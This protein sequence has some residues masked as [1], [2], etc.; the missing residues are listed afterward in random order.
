MNLNWISISQNT[1]RGYNRLIG[2]TGATQRIVIKAPT[3]EP[4]VYL[5]DSK[6]FHERDLYEFFDE[7][8]LFISIVPSAEGFSYRIYG[9]SG[10]LLSDK[11]PFNVSEPSAPVIEGEEEP[12]K[13]K[14][15]RFKKSESAVVGAYHALRRDAEQYAF[16]DAF[17]LLEER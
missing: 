10:E 3:K 12:V 14:S 4:F 16:E 13:K 15:N 1:P 9:T 5:S 8:K 2:E 7:Q 17:A 11:V 6:F